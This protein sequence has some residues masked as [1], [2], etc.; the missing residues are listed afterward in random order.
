MEKNCAD[1]GLGDWVL[2]TDSN[3]TKLEHPGAVSVGNA[4]K[5]CILRN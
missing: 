5:G 4:N 1:P 2:S 3:S